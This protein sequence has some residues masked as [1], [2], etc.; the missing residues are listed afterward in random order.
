MMKMDEFLNMSISDAMKLYAGIFN[1]NCSNEIKTGES[2]YA[3][4]NATYVTGIESKVVF[5]LENFRKTRE[6]IRTERNLRV[7]IK[8]CRY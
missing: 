2:I 4:T 6:T 7:E 3:I 5:E 1:G 8:G